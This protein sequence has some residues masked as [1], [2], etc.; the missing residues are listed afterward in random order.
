MSGW[1]PTH[2][3]SEWLRRE[4]PHATVCGRVVDVASHTQSCWVDDTTAGVQVH[5]SA[6]SFVD[7][8][9]GDWVSLQLS[10]SELHTVCQSARVLQPAR[11]HARSSALGEDWHRFYQND[12]QRLRMLHQRGRLLQLIRAFFDRAGFLEI[13]APQAVPSP[14][15][16]VHLQAMALE[17]EQRYLITSPEYQLKRLLTAGFRNIYSMGKVFRGRE[18]GSWHNPEFTMLEW[19]RAFDTWEA[20]AEDMAALY[21]HVATG[22]KQSTTFVYQNQWV[23]LSLPWERLTVEEATERYA[24]FAIHGFETTEELVG[25][26]TT[27]GWPVPAPP[28][29]WDDVFFSIFLHAVEPHLG[30]SPN[31]NQPVKPVVVYDWPRPLCALAQEKPGSPHLVERFEA[32]V[33]GLELCNGFGELCDAREQRIRCERDQAQRAERGLPVYPLDERFLQALESGMPPSGGVALGVDRMAMLLLNAP[34]IA[35]V[36]PFAWNEL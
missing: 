23:D 12:R 6:G 7:L 25:K 34:T 24:G 26:A 21:A 33:A 17:A 35:D 8:H 15:V 30:Q 2:T 3:L 1:K 18:S 16:E 19:Y 5:F 11:P 31:K 4:V 29:R 28:Y 9:L 20:V 22:L 13:E 10:R 36:L 14:G 27:H 32:Y